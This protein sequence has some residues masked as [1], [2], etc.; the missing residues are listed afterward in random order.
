MKSDRSSGTVGAVGSVAESYSNGEISLFAFLKAAGLTAVLCYGLARL[1]RNLL[2]LLWTFR[3]SVLTLT[4]VTL[5]VTDENTALVVLGWVALAIALGTS[6][7]PR[8]RAFSPFSADILRLRARRQEEEEIRRGNEF[9]RQAGI[10]KDD[11]VVWDARIFEAED[12]DALVLTTQALPGVSPVSLADKARAFQSTF[13][14]VRVKVTPLPAG[15]LQLVFYRS[16]PLDEGQVLNQPAALDPVK[17]KVTCAV[18]SE[19]EP[20]SIQFGDS[21]GMVVGGIPGSG[22]TAG[23]TSFLLPL[24][25]SPHVDLSVIDGKGGQD[26]ESYG[27]RCSTYIRGDE[28]LTPIVD[29]LS[30]FHSEMLE[31][32]DSQKERLGTSNFWNADVTTRDRASEPFKLL[33]ID[34]CQGIFETNGRSKEEKEQLGQILRYC[35][36]VVKRGRSAGFFI[37]F[38]TQ[39]PTSEALPTAIRDNAGLRIAFRLTTTA[40]ESAVLGATPEDPD[41]PRALAIPSSRKGGAVLATD[42]GK[43]EYVRFYYIPETVQENLL[44]GDS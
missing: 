1:I 38:I 15:A 27:P 2:S 36:A 32:L 12:A 33:V 4:F 20:V 31:R 37:I 11:G 30:A 39:K 9:L 28:D 24:A 14:A 42:T 35:S 5:F 17:M 7:Y 22:K 8:T 44:K 19:G 18:N 6:I 34:E 16:D 21:S 41:S 3:W 13:D 43:I 10:V 40:A 23:V 29:F 25:L 26:W